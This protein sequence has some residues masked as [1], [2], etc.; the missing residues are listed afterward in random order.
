MRAYLRG[1]SA[2]RRAGRGAQRTVLGLFGLL[3]FLVAWQLGSAVGLVNHTFFS[4]PLEV[5][6]V[7]I[8]EL[9]VPRFWRDV[10]TTGV[11]LLVGTVLAVGLA[12]PIGLATGWYT[13]LGYAVDP[14]LNFFN[15]LPRIAL[16]PLV[17]IW[18]GL[19]FEAKMAIVFLGAFFTIVISTNQGVKT[20]ERRYLDV[21]RGFGASQSRVFRSVVLPTSLP[22]IAAGLRLAVDRVLAGVI[23][24][25]LYAQTTGLGVA[26]ARAASALHTD[27]MLFIVLLFTLL[28]IVLTEGLYRL[29]RRLLHWR[30]Q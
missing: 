10:W 24:A 19:G 15:A 21:A 22:F 9:G 18:F 16:L 2:A 17:V 20:A 8:V 6:Q 5:L 23:I 25:E 30:P 3:A 11:E 7:G 29:E 28:G 27:R 12:I 1:A 4:S 26:L 13:R 14:W